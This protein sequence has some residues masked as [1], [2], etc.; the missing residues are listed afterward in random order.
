MAIPHALQRLQSEVP[1]CLA[2]S[3]RTKPGARIPSLQTGFALRSYSW[4]LAQ[5]SRLLLKLQQGIK[6]RAA[7]PS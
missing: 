1:P 4:Y 3:C 7:L 2:L 6:S 5:R